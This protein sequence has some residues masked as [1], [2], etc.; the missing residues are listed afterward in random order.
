MSSSHNEKGV[1]VVD[2]GCWSFVFLVQ[3][4]HKNFLGL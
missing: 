4:G 2:L 3:L 1:D